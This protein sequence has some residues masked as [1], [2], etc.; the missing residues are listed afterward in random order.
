MMYCAGSSLIKEIGH[1]AK[2]KCEPV[3]SRRTK[4][5]KRGAGSSGKVQM[6]SRWGKKGTPL[7]SKKDS[8][9]SWNC[10]ASDRRTSSEPTGQRGGRKSHSRTFSGATWCALWSGCTATI[11]EGGQITAPK[12]RP[13]IP[14]AGRSKSQK[15]RRIK[16][17]TKREKQIKL[18]NGDVYDYQYK[19][20]GVYYTDSVSIG[21]R[22]V[23][24]IN[25]GNGWQD[26]WRT[27]R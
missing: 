23:E 9:G 16:M 18:Q 3:M 14:T 25:Y 26:A 11:D 6:A 12:S 24:K 10:D 15:K 21:A 20:N 7:K 19:K 2:R 4:R 13:W 8:E 5:I 22:L 1:E 27:K 17:K